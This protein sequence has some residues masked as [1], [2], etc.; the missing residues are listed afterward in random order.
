[1]RPSF[2]ILRKFNFFF[3]SIFFSLEFVAWIVYH[4]SCI[5]R[6]IVTMATMEG[7]SRCTANF[8]RLWLTST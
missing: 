5:K 4:N 6:V 2:D 3:Q 1:M 7:R 8:D